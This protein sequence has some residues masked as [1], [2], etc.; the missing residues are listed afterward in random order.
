MS[1]EFI[2]YTRRFLSSH[3]K[4]ASI[5]EQL[6]R[7]MDDVML[8]FIPPTWPLVAQAYFIANLLGGLYD[9]ADNP[10]SGLLLD[11]VWF[12]DARG[13]RRNFQTDHNV[14]NT[15]VLGSPYFSPHDSELRLLKSGMLPC[16]TWP[17]HRRP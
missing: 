10:V 16:F 11:P 3:L 7:C 13:L 17:S 5:S 15:Y 8:E 4:E 6:G 1:A 14:V 12:S 2:D 9:L